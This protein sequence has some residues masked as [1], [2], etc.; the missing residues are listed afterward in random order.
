MDATIRSAANT[1]DR[2]AAGT[3][4]RG[5]VGTTIRGLVLLAA[6][7]LLAGCDDHTRYVMAPPPPPPPPVY[8]YAQP[9]IETAEHNGFADGVRDGQRDRYEGHSYRPEH[10]DRFEDAPGY[11]RELG[12]SHDQYRYYYRDGYVH[13]YHQGYTRG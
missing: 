8:P 6:I 3:A 2:S 4:T 10:S 13:G 11:Y 5:A 9:L 7:G 12:G 1:T